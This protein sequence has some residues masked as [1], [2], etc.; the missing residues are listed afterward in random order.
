ML[1]VLKDKKIRVT[2]WNSLLIIIG[3]LCCL[4]PKT[5]ISIIETIFFV[6]LIVYGIYCLLCYLFS[7]SL[8][9]RDN[10]L[11]FESIFYILAGIL[12]TFVED[13]FIICA[14]IYFTFQGLFILSYAIDLKDSN[15]KNWYVDALIGLGI[16]VLGI[17]V[18]VLCK[19]T[20][21]ILSIILGLLMIGYGV[22]NLIR[23]FA[24]SRNYYDITFIVTDEKENK[25]D[26]T[27]DDDNFTDFN[28]K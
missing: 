20:L 21:T 13:I 18:I 23:I 12:L 15:V 24:M 7:T 9:T 22:S 4:L 3:L 27:P 6:L 28:V 5:A 8:T 11:L 2:I 17:V 1:N 14:G 19:K 10:S 25:S 26:E 16:L